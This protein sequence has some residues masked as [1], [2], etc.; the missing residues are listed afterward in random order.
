MKILQDV[1]YT[2]GEIRNLSFLQ[3]SSEKYSMVKYHDEKLQFHH[4]NHQHF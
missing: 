2:K 4:T 3:P 1:E